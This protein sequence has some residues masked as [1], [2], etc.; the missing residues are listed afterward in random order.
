MDVL[1]FGFVFW[2]K[3]VI[4]DR[5]FLYGVFFIFFFFFRYRLVPGSCMHLM[6]FLFVCFFLFTCITLYPP[7]LTNSSSLHHCVCCL[8]NPSL[9]QQPH[10]ASD[11]SVPTGPTRWTEAPSRGT[12]WWSRRCW[13]PLRTGYV[14]CVELAG[15]RLFL[16]LT[17]RSLTSPATHF[18]LQMCQAALV[19]SQKDGAS[20]TLFHLGGVADT[21][22]AS[23]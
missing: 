21:E 14:L 15:F 2:Y 19:L 13:R 23:D 12:A 18:G 20:P 8:G 4:F 11:P 10:Q 3:L 6:F 5:F 22:R 7:P 17:R 9:L 16:S 1:E